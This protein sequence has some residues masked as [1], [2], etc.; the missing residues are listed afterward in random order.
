MTDDAHVDALLAVAEPLV[1]RPPRAMIVARLVPDAAELRVGVRLARRAAIVHS[2]RRGVVARTC[3]FTSSAPGEDLARLATELDVDLL[4]TDAA[5]R[6]AG[7]RG[8]RRAAQR[9]PRRR[10]V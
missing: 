2:K 6:A 8:S 1:R 7:R 9:P 4:L 3:S 10:A 5:E